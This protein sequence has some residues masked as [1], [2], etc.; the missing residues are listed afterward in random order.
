MPCSYLFWSSTVF[1]D[2]F[3]SSK[4]EFIDATH[5]KIARQRLHVYTKKNV[6]LYK[7]KIYYILI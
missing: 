6:N 7:R 4:R 2:L 3:N 1:T 5:Y